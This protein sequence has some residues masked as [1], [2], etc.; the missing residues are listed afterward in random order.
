MHRIL[1]V[2]AKIERNGCLWLSQ[3]GP[4]AHFFNIFYLMYT[5]SHFPSKYL[6]VHSLCHDNLLSQMAISVGH[7]PSCFCPFQ[8]LLLSSQSFHSN[9]FSSSSFISVLVL[10]PFEN[11]G[12]A[13]DIVRV[14]DVSGY[15]FED[16]RFRSD[17]LNFWPLGWASLSWRRVGVEG[18]G[19]Q[20]RHELSFG[21]A[22][23]KKELVISHS[24][25]LYPKLQTNDKKK[26]EFYWKST[27]CNHKSQK[28][29]NNSYKNADLSID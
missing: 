27:Q 10:F 13:L 12:L 1:Y 18:H 3:A 22:G 11:L 4:C 17:T 28:N 29:D 19:R 2:R 15:L 20:V 9:T 6:H 5:A 14:W 26:F 25:W 16:L 8:S 23:C 24:K 7:C 21:Y